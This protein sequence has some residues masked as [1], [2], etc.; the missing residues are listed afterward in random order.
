MATYTVEAPDGKTI[1]LEGPSGASQEDVIAQAQ[2]LYK[3]QESKPISASS[4][5]FGETGGGAALGRPM[6]RGQL[7]VQA[8]PRPLESAMAAL[9][10]S[11]ID[12]P[13]GAAQLATGGNV[14]AQTA[15]RLA[16]EAKPYQEENPMSYLGGQVAGAVA[17]A[18]GI[19]KGIG[20]IPSFAK[21]API[22]QNVGGAMIQGALMPNETGK[23]G[24]EFYGQKAQEAP[25]NA[26]LGTIP[27]VASKG[28]ELLG[29]LLRKGAGISTGAGE[30]AFKQAYKAGKETNPEFLANMRGQAPMENVLNSAKANLADMR[31]AKNASYRS[32]ME[33]IT[34]DKSVLNFKE[35]DT[36]L[37]EAINVGSFKGE[38]TN[39][40]AIKALQDIKKSVNRWKSLDPAEYHTPEGMDALKQ[41]IGAILEDIP[42]GT[43]ARHIADDIYHSVKDTIKTQAPKYDEVMKD[44]SQS[45]ELIREIEKSLSLGNKASVATGLNKLQ[46][47]MRNNVISNYGYRQE[48]ANKLMEQGGRNIMPSLA[49]QALSSWTPR[50]IV[51]QGLDVGAGLSALGGLTNLPATAATM[52]ATSPRLMGEAAYK[53]GQIAG[54]T[55][56]MTDEQKKLAQL[57]L[58]RGAQGAT[59]E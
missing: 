24:T 7:N 59:N 40:N 16:Q 12:V 30:E 22:A 49:G 5:Q 10:K 31:T 44:Y 52:A 41:R 20:M 28:G 3:P 35:I 6:N 48:L 4:G 37:K 21:T 42:Y 33:D 15:Q 46:S 1:T 19:S 11:M 32:G 8:Q 38:T 58:I 53:A 56:K 45:S 26:L 55:P 54:K 57:L 17:P 43:K 39:P 34:S 23:T 50:G 47:L 25:V 36:K 18:A 2:Q 29:S 14:G 13:V 27:T 51:G 9:T